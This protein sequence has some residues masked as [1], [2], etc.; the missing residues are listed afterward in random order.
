[1]SP[2]TLREAAEELGVSIRTLQRRRSTLIA[3]GATHGQNG[4]SIPQKLSTR[5]VRG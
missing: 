5:C 1:M 2:L 4:W 3:A